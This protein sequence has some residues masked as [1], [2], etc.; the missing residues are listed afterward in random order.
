MIKIQ[1][2]DKEEGEDIYSLFFEMKKLL[3]KKGFEEEKNLKC[4]MHKGAMHNEKAWA[5]R[6]DK[7]LIFLL[8]R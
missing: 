1:N 3:K 6:L 2:K 8:K 7:A 4:F 5:E